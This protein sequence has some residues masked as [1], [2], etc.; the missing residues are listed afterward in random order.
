MLSISDGQCGKCAHF[1][2]AHSDE[3]KLVQIRISG[4]APEDFTDACGHPSMRDLGLS[5]TPIS[6]CTGFTPAKSA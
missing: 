5:V 1:G 4:R 6:S 2:E 3:P